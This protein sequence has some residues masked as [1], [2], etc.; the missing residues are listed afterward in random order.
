MNAKKEDKQIEKPLN[1]Q[2][3]NENGLVAEVS[4]IEN[5][6]EVLPLYTPAP[7]TALPN[8]VLKK[9]QLSG[10]FTKPPLPKPNTTAIPPKPLALESAANTDKTS[11]TV[12][13]T[14]STA[15]R[16]DAKATEKP[17]TTHATRPTRRPILSIP[18]RRPTP[19][20]PR[21]PLGL[22]PPAWFTNLSLLPINPLLP[23]FFINPFNTSTTSSTNQPN[24]N[25]G[26]GL[27]AVPWTWRPFNN[28]NV[29]FPHNRILE[30]RPPLQDETL[31]TAE[32][33]D[34][35]FWNALFH[36]DY[37]APGN[38]VYKDSSEAHKTTENG[39][40]SYWKPW[41]FL[42]FFSDNGDTND[43]ATVPANTQIL[44][45]YFPLKYPFK[46]KI[47]QT[48]AYEMEKQNPE[49][50]EEILVKDA[51]SPDGD[52][53]KERALDATAH[54]NAHT[55]AISSKKEDDKKSSLMFELEMPKPVVQLFQGFM[56]TFM[57]QQN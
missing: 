23:N 44:H 47:V 55:E 24:N 35:A 30:T 18:S 49:Y 26:F 34:L 29:F 52:S 6:T 31:T 5:T 27:F 2:K 10:N 20:R 41:K 36:R 57:P 48:P 43:V 45:V 42:K 14:T 11:N 46:G 9:E 3:L 13:S 38:A 33:R 37:K 51:I 39:N 8:F 15:I 12:S 53:I 56:E 21:P 25:L 50:N 28:T 22:R 40:D 32:T 54:R 16:D 17:T 19:Q 1:E 4:K 7:V